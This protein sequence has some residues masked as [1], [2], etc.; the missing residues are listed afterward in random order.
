MKSDAVVTIRLNKDLKS[1][2]QKLFADL[3]LDMTSAVNIFLRQAVRNDGIPFEVTKVP[4]TLTLSAIEDAE[5]GKLSKPFD[6]IADLEK[7][8]DA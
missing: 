2:A 3:G 6:N 4:N 7:S 5:K 8:L 1:K